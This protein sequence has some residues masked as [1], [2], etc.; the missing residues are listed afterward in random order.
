MMYDLIT[1]FFVAVAAVAITSILLTLR[2]L[3]VR[4]CAKCFYE[5]E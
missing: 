2:N 5:A 3:V 1:H 4:P